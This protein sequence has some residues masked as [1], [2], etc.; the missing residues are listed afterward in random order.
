MKKKKTATVL[1][2][3]PP[4]LEDEKISVE[5]KKIEPPNKDIIDIINKD[6]SKVDAK[7]KVNYID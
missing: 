7:F 1:K 3:E 2:V 5:N 4:D 6:F